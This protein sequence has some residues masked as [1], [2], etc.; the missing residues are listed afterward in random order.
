M[1]NEKII[2]KLYGYFYS[3]GFEDYRKGWITGACPECGEDREGKY[4]IHLEDNRGNCFICGNKDKPLEVIRKMEKVHTISEVYQLLNAFEGFKYAPIRRGHRIVKDQVK[5]KLKLPKEFKLIGVYNN[6][7]A[8]IVKQNLK[9]RGF[10]IKKLMRAGVGYCSTGEYAN[11]IIIPYTANGELVYFNAR[12]FVEL[13][14]KFQNP[15]T[16]E[17]GIG[18]NQMIYN[19]DALYIY[20]KIYVFESATNS[21]TLGEQAVGTGGKILSAWQLSALISSPCK[22][23]IIGLDDDAYYEALCIA[24]YL[25]PY[26]KVKVLRFPEG[27]DANKLGRKETLKLEKE[28]K[29]KTYKQFY[30]E[31]LHERAVNPRY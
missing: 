19:I 13:G 31:V 1:Y 9:N 26:K 10:N 17:F 3:H 30:K 2:G 22:E 11:R 20:E 25:S 14:S 27:I 16:E 6:K 21:L 29:F 24:L 18:K 28:T 7:T 23:I 5:K 8:K 4:A 15:S 12:R